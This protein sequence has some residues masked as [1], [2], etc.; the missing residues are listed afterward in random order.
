MERIQ[1]N[2]A[3]IDQLLVNFTKDVYDGLT[4]K[5]NLIKSSPAFRVV[6]DRIG[7]YNHSSPESPIVFIPKYFTSKKSIVDYFIDDVASKDK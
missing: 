5:D 6:S 4:N 7:W 1:N 3:S 2:Q